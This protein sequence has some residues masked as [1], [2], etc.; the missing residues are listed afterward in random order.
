MTSTDK[1]TQELRLVSP[2]SDTFE[3]LVGLYYTDEDSGIDPQVISPVDAGTEDIIDGFP[4]VLGTAF[5]RSTYEELALFA[6]ATWHVTDRFDLS[7]GGRASENDQEASQALDGLLVGGTHEVRRR[8]VLREPVHLLGF[9]ALRAHGHDVDLRARRDGLPAGRTQ[10]A[11]G[12]G[13]SG[14]AGDV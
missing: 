5:V 6:N 7:F 8:E 4:V 1:F 11:A 2:K 13:A 14:H 10:R 3:W 9:A 12:D